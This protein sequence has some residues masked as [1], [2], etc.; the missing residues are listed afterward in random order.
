MGLVEEVKAFPPGHYYSDGKFTCYRDMTKVDTVI[1]DD[2]EI[3]CKNIHDK[4]VAGIEKRLDADA[5]L[6]FLLSGGLDSSVCLGLAVRE[7]G[8]EEVLALSIKYGQ[9]HKKE[10]EASEKVAAYYGVKTE[11][12]LTGF[13]FIG[14]RIDH[15]EK[16]G[17]GPFFEFGL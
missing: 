9:K 3:V 16:L 12:F 6:G 10:I 4:L 13:K 17:S 7:Y 15:Y 11:Q 14:N 2:I 5:P 8:A 1:K